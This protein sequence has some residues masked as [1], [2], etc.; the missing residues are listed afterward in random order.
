MTKYDKLIEAYEAKVYFANGCS[1]SYLDMLII[2]SE[3]ARDI[4]HLTIEQYVKVIATDR[5]LLSQAQLFYQNIQKDG[6]L[7]EW[8]RDEN[9]P[10]SHWWWYL[11][12]LT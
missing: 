8:R 2:R 6:D 10:D 11:D 12:A 4:C 5:W 3:I 9:V 1:L 7:A